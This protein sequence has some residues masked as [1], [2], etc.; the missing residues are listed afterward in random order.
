[1]LNSS[2]GKTKIKESEIDECLTAQEV[3]QK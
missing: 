1:V 3:K 2:I